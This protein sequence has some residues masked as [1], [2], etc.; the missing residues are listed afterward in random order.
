MARAR[1][2]CPSW[3]RSN[4]CLLTKEKLMSTE[5][6][7]IVAEHCP[8]NGTDKTTNSS[9]EI[10]TPLLSHGSASVRLRAC[11]VL[12]S[13]T[14][15]TTAL[16]SGALA[17]LVANLGYLHDDIDAF[18]RGELFSIFRRF[19]TRVQQSRRAEDRIIFSIFPGPRQ[20]SLGTD[21]DEMW[22]Y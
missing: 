5:L 15:P 3:V 6:L 12:L 20:S 2:L 19:L 13:S 14:S 7:E 4:V 11:E 1:G 21:L 22:E 9:Y 10:F 17:C 18:H 16:P 8:G